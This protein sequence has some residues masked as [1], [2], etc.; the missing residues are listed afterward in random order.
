MKV[1]ISCC[2]TLD[3]IEIDNEADCR[4]SFLLEKRHGKW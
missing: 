1:T 4:F 3:N 2:F